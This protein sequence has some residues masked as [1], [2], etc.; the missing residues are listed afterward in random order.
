MN[1]SFLKNNQNSENKHGSGFSILAIIFIFIVLNLFYLVF[2]YLIDGTDEITIDITILVISS[3]F[4]F[5][6]GFCTGLYTYG[7]P[8]KTLAVSTNMVFIGVIVLTFIGNLISHAC[9]PNAV[10]A[11]VLSIPAILVTV[12]G[13]SASTL[14]MRT[15]K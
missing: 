13:L 11:T 9:I 4:L 2:T 1:N 14:F 15:H 12:L 10:M 5:L 6:A 3:L 8:R 7:K